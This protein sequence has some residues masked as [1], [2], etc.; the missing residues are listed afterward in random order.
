[1]RTRI[2]N[3]AVAALALAAAACNDNTCPT[4]SPQVSALPP[5][6]TERANELVSYPIRLCPTCNQT[7]SSCDV[8]ISGSTIFLDPKVETCSSSNSCPPSC[9][10]NASTCNFTAPAPGQYTIE[11]YDPATNKTLIANLNVIPSGN[12]SCGLAKAGL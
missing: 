3:A 9:Q 11:V 8:Q 4:E 5:D 12:E 1:M 2:R 7:V 10:A 6:C